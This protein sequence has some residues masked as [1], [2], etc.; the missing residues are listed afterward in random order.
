MLD[1]R[2]MVIVDIAGDGSVEAAAE[3]RAMAKVDMLFSAGL[4]SHDLRRGG[5]RFTCS[6]PGARRP[7]R[8]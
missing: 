8:S 7:Q 3:L 4:R 6:P 1:R 2:E 5:V